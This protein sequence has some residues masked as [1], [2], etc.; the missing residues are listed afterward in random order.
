[1]RTSVTI[2]QVLS[3]RCSACCGRRLTFL[4]TASR[5]LLCT[6][7][8]FSTDPVGFCPLRFLQ[9]LLGHVTRDHSTDQNPVFTSTPTSIKNNM[10][11]LSLHRPGKSCCLVRSHNRTELPGPPARFPAYF[12]CNWKLPYS[13]H[14][15]FSCLGPATFGST[16]THHIL[17][18]HIRH[19]QRQCKRCGWVLLCCSGHLRT[20]FVPLTWW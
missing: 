13:K 11:L 6:T 19:F 20:N 5:L 17:H 18:F 9:T 4:G 1:M 7:L 15:F 3:W 8:W 2:G 12:S 16:G 10:S 14:A